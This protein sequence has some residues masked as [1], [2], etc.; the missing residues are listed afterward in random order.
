MS[1]RSIAA[2]YWAGAAALIV[3]VLAHPA[4][5]PAAWALLGVLAAVTIGVGV[6]RNRPARTW[7]WILLA[8]AVLISTAADLLDF[9]AAAGDAA[10]LLTAVN[11]LYL[12]SFLAAIAALMRFARS[13]T[14]GLAPAGALDAL[15]AT[16]VLV[17][18][19]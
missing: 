17:L 10:E 4:W 11:L 19:I 14:A 2:S 7:P 6:M 9:R 15:I 3:V 12:V 16:V 5:A 13:D 8:T 1:T 18:L